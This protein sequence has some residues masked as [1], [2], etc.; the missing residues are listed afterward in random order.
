MNKLLLLALLALVAFLALNLA[1]AE[2]DDE[3]D[4]DSQDYDDDDEDADDDEQNIY[5][6]DDAGSNN[7][8][9]HVNYAIVDAPISVGENLPIIIGKPV[10]VLCGVVNEGDVAVNVSGIAGLVTP[11][12]NANHLLQNLTGIR[13]DF[14]VPPNDEVTFQYA[15]QSVE[16]REGVVAQ[17]A[18]MVYYHDNVRPYQRVFF[19]K[20][21]EFV[22]EDSE[23]NTQDLFTYLLAVAVVVL[24]GMTFFSVAK[25]ISSSTP[26]ETG[27]QGGMSSTGEWDSSYM[28]PKMAG[29]KLNKNK[30]KKKN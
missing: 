6:E 10:Q 28:D 30:K 22:V 13:Y 3:Y 2:E 18:L 11:A 4:D 29:R 17:I 24:L 9:I 1:Y 15:F 7:P 19:N 12:Q 21:V 16:N 26:L 20:T 27:T 14:L 5:M 8:F 23:F 25:G